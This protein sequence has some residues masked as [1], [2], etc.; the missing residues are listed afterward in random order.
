V[1]NVGVARTVAK[2]TV[3]NF[4]TTIS[5][6][7]IG[8]VT[9]IVLA[10]SLGTEQYG[11][12]AYLVWFLSIVAMI[13]DVGMS[14]MPQRFIAEAL[15]SGDRQGVRGLIQV[16][17]MCRGAMSLFVVLLIIITYR[18]WVGLTGY[19]DEQFYF[20][21]VAL[22]VLPHGL[23]Y[24]LIAIFRGFQKYE[25]AAYVTLGTTPLRLV[26][27]IVLMA[28][29]F[30]I[31]ELLVL[32]VAILTLG[33]LIGLYLLRRLIPLRDLFLPL[34]LDAVMKK[35][36]LKFALIVVGIMTVQYLSSGQMPVFFIGLY[37]PV[38]EVGFYALASRMATMV[39]T[40]TTTAFTLVLTPAIA[41]QFGKGDMEKIRTIYITSARYLMMVGLPLT[42]G[43][44][45]L[46]SPIIVLLYGVDYSPAVA[47]MQILIV[48][49]AFASI[50]D[51]AGAVVYGINRPDLVLKI[52]VVSALLNIGLCILLV[53]R[54]G[55]L[56]AAVACSIP[57]IVTLPIYVIFA[58]RKV[59][60]TWP[61]WDTL[62]II[63]ASLI[64]GLAVYF[65]QTQLGVALSLA[66]GIPMGIVI[67]L[68]TIPFLK[69][70]REQDFVILERARG[71]LPPVLQKHY[72]VITRA[73]ERFFL[74]AKLPVEK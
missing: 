74:G 63:L 68:A 28:L 6:L 54:Y 56:G 64:M 11:V 55:I 1:A 40:F 50:S 21:L 70:V 16:T 4:I 49:F 29:G 14:R 66:L 35:R 34:S 67:Y 41:E 33:V 13:T 73:A 58:A 51:T 36:V 18:F 19:S 10:R 62:K 57:P 9:G 24:A 2:N 45:A 27:V 53:P 52:S 39:L 25:Y 60:A 71:F 26:L 30:G 3:F 43:V 22:A 23:N 17:L 8:L 7:A 72:M 5:E 59:G 46:A 31:W 69:V 32:Q 65:L 12:Y 48:Q 61:V 20:I 15:G 38:E 44:I 42:A 37:C 47:P